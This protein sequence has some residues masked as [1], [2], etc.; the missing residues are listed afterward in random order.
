MSNI[1]ALKRKVQAPNLIEKIPTNN[2]T[3]TPVLD[4]VYDIR[5]W[6]LE[7]GIDINTVD[8]KYEMA[9]IMS[10]LQGMVFKNADR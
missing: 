4:M 5:V 7:E 9:T 8:F 6:A 2:S 1:V 10:V 3:P